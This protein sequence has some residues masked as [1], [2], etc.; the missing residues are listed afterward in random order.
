MPSVI[1]VEQA[2]GDEGGERMGGGG[3]VGARVVEDGERGR[4]GE[5]GVGPTGSVWRLHYAFDL[6]DL[7]CAFAK[8]TDNRGGETLRRFALQPGDVALGDRAYGTPTGVAHAQR[9]GADVLVRINLQ[10]MPLYTAHA[11]RLSLLPRLRKLAIG[12]VRD[13]RA[14]VR[15]TAGLIPG[16]LVA[17]R[18]S[19]GATALAQRRLAQRARKTGEQ[20]QP[21]THEAAAYVL[22]FTTLPRRG[23]SARRVAKLYRLRWQ[24]ELA[25]KRMKTLMNYGQLPKHDP[26][27]SRAW[28]YGKLL[29]ALLAERLIR[30]ADAFSPWGYPLAPA[31]QSL[32]RDGLRRP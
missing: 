8:L 6:Q 16:R 26:A 2:A 28:L 9:A 14:W 22:V 18:K 27:S 12:E 19:A 30:E 20:L 15:G 10:N 3:A 17:V 4:V 24:V 5:A 29:V 21:E 32:A 31:T 7:S 13:W 25:F 1:D 23:F 11:K